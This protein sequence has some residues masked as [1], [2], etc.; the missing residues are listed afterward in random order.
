LADDAAGA[1]APGVVEPDTAS[2]AAPLPSTAAPIALLMA[3]F[4]H[5]GWLLSL[6]LLTDAIHDALATFSPGQR[7]VRIL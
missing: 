3:I 7:N 2:A 5:T 6:V 1:G 4:F